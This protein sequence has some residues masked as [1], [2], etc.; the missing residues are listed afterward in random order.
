MPRRIVDGEGIWQSRKI[1]QLNSKSRAEYANL[2]PLAEANGTF[3]CDPAL[4]WSRVYSFNRQDMTEGQVRAILDDL[5]RV[6][7]LFRWP[8]KDGRMWGYWIGIEKPGRLPTLDRANKLRLQMGEPVPLE[9]LSKFLESVGAT[10][11]LRSDYAEGLVREGK[12]KVGEGIQGAQNAPLRRRPSKAEF[13]LPEWIPTTPWNDYLEMRRRIRKP[14]T[15]AAMVLTV[16]KLETLSGKDPEIVRQVLEQ[17]IENS[18]QAVYDLKPAYQRHHSG[19]NG[20]G[21]NRKPF[22]TREEIAK[23]SESVYEGTD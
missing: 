4:V 3:E 17:S 23:A 21:Q 18:W 13:T 22:L 19:G 10:E 12:G 14:A 9:L 7:L 16:H 6:K 5:E 8:S 11:Q 15:Q 2:L 1:K 20:N